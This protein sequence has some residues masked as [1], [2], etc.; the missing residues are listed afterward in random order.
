MIAL[1]MLL[2]A[3]ESGEITENT[4]RIIEWSSGNTAI[5]LAIISR[6]YGL[7][8]VS[9]YISNKNS[10]AK[11]QLLRFFVSSV[12]ASYS[13]AHTQSGTGDVTTRVMFLDPI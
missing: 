5:S 12:T 3:V 11:M 8:D 13:A 4:K 7:A 1:N 9:A 2:R 6:I 10:E